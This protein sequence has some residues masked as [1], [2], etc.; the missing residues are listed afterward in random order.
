MLLFMIHSK[1]WLA[2]LILSF[3]GTVRSLN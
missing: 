3:R 2:R 1:S